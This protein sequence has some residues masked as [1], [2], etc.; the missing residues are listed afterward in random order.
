MSG[1]FAHK[2][3]PDNTIYI[4]KAAECAQLRQPLA[5]EGHGTCYQHTLVSEYDCLKI[6]PS[7]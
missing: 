7:S 5:F 2:V 1:D 6:L 3:D 4:R